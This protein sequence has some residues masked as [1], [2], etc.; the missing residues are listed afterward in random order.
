MYPATIYLTDDCTGP[1]G[2]GR[3]S[4]RWLYDVDTGF[5]HGIL[6]EMGGEGVRV[7]RREKRERGVCG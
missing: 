4:E 2:V 5:L 6:D 1:F 7:W 3:F